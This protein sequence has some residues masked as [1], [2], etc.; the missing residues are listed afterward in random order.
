MPEETYIKTRESVHRMFGRIAPGYDTANRI[1]TFG[2][3]RIWRR[4]AVRAAGL[5][6]GARVLDIGCG[7]GEMACEVLR[8]VK[9]AS[10]VAADFSSGMIFEGKRSKRC[11]PIMWCL[12]DACRLP[13]PDD[14]FDAVLSGYLVRNVPD[15]MT[16]FQEQVRV[17]KAGGK[18]ICLETCPPASGLKGLPVKI[19]TAFVIPLIGK[20]I[21]GDS[22]AYRYLHESTGN[23]MEPDPL[24]SLIGR[25]GLVHLYFRRFMMGTQAVHVAAKRVD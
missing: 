10:V 7:T 17:V 11:H 6:R 20:F 1:I 3:D 5:S 12:G 14:C 8:Q 13:F 21:S 23:F 25:S 22:R 18:V 2:R 16:A 9:D 19:Y 4:F 24:A 15:V